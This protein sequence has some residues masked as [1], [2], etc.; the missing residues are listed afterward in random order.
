MERCYHENMKYKQT[1]LP[2]GAK[3]YYVKNKINESTAVDINFDC[4][5]RCDWIPGLAH[6]T[7]HMFFTGT[8]D[9]TKEDIAKKYFDFIDVN[10]GTSTRYINFNGQVFTKEFED[11]LNTVAMM[12][13]ESTFSEENVKNEIPVVQ[14][15]IA[16]QK[17]KFKTMSAWLADY[18]TFETPEYKN[19]TLGSQKSVSTIKSEDVKKF[20]NKYFVT[21]NLEVFVCSPYSINKVKKLVIKNLVDKLPADNSFKKMPYF[22]NNV[23]N[24]NFY[25]IENKTIK[26]SYVYI[27]FAMKRN[28]WDF[29]FK[30]KFGLVMDMLNDYSEGILNA[31]RLKKSL[32]YGAGLRDSYYDEN[33]CCG[34]ST[35]CDKEN[36]NE[37][38][39]TLAKYLKEVAKNGFTQEQLDKAK[40]L[41]EFGEAIKE[42]RLK[43]LT[44]K[45]YQFKYYGKILKT[46]DAKKAI[47][48]ATLEEVNALYREVFEN[49]TVSLLVYGDSTKEDVMSKKEFN[50]VFK[51][52][53]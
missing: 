53:S 50:Q 18:L 27:N 23:K 24:N 28:R 26:K 46:K 38:I 17:D 22:Y 30:R 12:I 42:I 49:P 44:G 39:S 6:F 33:S 37:V 4:G 47:R 48:S 16:R 20:V 34:F 7:E 31:L 35:E 14:Q 52:Q 9:L 1:N 19:T 2:N 45:L 5:S 8:K 32:V 41:Y 13:T 15:E 3:L 43:K 10:A 25:K 11:Y 40:R 21:N 51:M 29:D 36:V